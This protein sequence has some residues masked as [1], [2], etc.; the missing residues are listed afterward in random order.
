MAFSS[1]R[2]E[3]LGLSLLQEQ[4]QL[5]SRWAVGR[6][7]NET[8][9]VQITRQGI[10]PD[11]NSRILPSGRGR[12]GS[13]HG[14]CT[15]CHGLYKGGIPG[16]CEAFDGATGSRTHSHVGQPLRW[17]HVGLVLV[18][19]GSLD[20]CIWGMPPHWLLNPPKAPSIWQW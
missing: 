8:S 17:S 2:H 5:P 12:S 13:A 3:H 9:P 11:S 7:G 10:Q 16:S 4:L 19:P 6:E 20:P 18:L 1:V 15:D 14:V